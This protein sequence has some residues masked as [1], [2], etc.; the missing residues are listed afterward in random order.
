M[1]SFAV[2]SIVVGSLVGVACDYDIPDLPG[3]AAPSGGS[4]AGGGDGCTFMGCPACEAPLVCDPEMGCVE[5]QTN[6]D[7]TNDAATICESYRC[8][9]C[10]ISDI[11]NC[12]D[13]DT[14]F[15]GQCANICNQPADCNGVQGCFNPTCDINRCVCC[16]EN[17]NCVQENTNICAP[18]GVCR[19]CLSDS[20]CLGVFDDGSRPK[21]RADGTCVACLV[22]EDCKQPAECQADNTCLP[23]CCSTSDCVLGSS[24]PVCDVPS[25]LCVAC[26]STRECLVG[27]CDLDSGRCIQC[28]SD[29]DCATE[30]PAC[31][32]DVCRECS[33]TQPCADPNVC[34]D[35][36]CFAPA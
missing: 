23:K 29:G 30:L 33:A 9:Q 24:E 22:A 18:N 5:C 14:C 26:T 35:S 12:Q 4:G 17:S 31:V 34:V 13:N 2:A 28:A 19:Q 32:D 10:T 7:C 6:A 20:D 16:T 1:R 27:T 21:C 11:S 8:V 36:V 3:G 25:G 15:N